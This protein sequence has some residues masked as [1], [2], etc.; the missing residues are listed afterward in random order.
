MNNLNRFKRENNDRYPGN[1]KPCW[2]RR[3]NNTSSMSNQWAEG[4]ETREENSV[5]E[6]WSA[7]SPSYASP[8]LAM[9]DQYSY[10]NVFDNSSSHEP[11]QNRHLPSLST[12]HF[13]DTARLPIRSRSHTIPLQ[14]FFDPKRND[15][16]S[17]PLLVPNSNVAERPVSCSS[18]SSST[19][20]NQGEHPV[21]YLTDSLSFM[22]SSTVFM[23]DFA[24]VSIDRGYQVIKAINIPWSI[25]AADIKRIISQNQSVQIPSVTELPQSVHIIMDVK[26]GKTLG[27][28]FI[29]CRLVQG[30][31]LQ[32]VLPELA[33]LMPVQGR[34]LR[35]TIYYNRKCAERPFEYLISI[36]MNIPWKQP[37][38]V[39]TIQRDLIYECYK[40]GTEKGFS[41]FERD[42]LPTLV[43]AAI[44]CPGFSIK[45]K[46][47]ILT[48]AKVP[49]PEDLAC[50]MNEPT[51][52]VD[53]GILDIIR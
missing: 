41:P 26:S 17:T 22:S 29:E 36:V 28:A 11:D 10:N 40:L 23:D 8:L 21:R 1:Q 27:V 15:N 14:N 52:F 30:Q 34:R 4:S 6:I 5:R 20:L 9:W 18:A 16:W 46:N 53:S 48:N 51:M 49:C 24:S 31:C 2:V 25:S 3:S 32:S 35:F 45:Q 47:G 33:K 43:R 39:T 19:V 12:G 50:Y 42:L 44:L 7:S 38:T 37:R 13:L